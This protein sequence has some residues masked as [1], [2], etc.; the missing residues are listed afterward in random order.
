MLDALGLIEKHCK[1]GVLI[2]ANLLVLYLIGGVNRERIKT[3]KRTRAYT[4]EDFELLVWLVSCFDKL[5]TTPHVLTEVSNLTGNL[6]GRERSAVR[7][8]VALV[9]DKMEECI[10]RSK[11]VVRDACFE[12]LGLTDAAV[13]RLCERG[14]LV[15]TDDLDLYLALQN[16]GADAVK[17]THIRSLGWS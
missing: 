9:V 17:F 1:T 7:S 4:F 13:A 16:R 12:R 2:D 3:F 6:E 10:E 15:L 5:Y 14:T 11:T 8:L